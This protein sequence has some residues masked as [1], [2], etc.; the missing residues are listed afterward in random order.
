MKHV[1]NQLKLE[2]ILKRLTAHEKIKETHKKAEGESTESV[3]PCQPQN[4]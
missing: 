3:I 1:Q 2:D 4:P